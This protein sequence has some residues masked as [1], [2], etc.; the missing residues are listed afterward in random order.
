MGGVAD[1]LVAAK[2]G[3]ATRFSSLTLSSDGGV[4]EP[5]RST[6][7]SF[8]R[9]GRPIPALNKP[10][11]IYARLFGI[12]TG[13]DAK[14]AKLRLKNS[15]NMLDRVLA[16]SK[17]VKGRL[18]THDQRK[19]DEYLESVRTIEQRVERAQAWLDVPKPKVDPN[20]LKESKEPK[21]EEA[22]EPEEAPEEASEDEGQEGGQPGGVPGGV[23]GGKVGGKG[24]FLVKRFGPGM[25]KPKQIGG[26]RMSASKQAV[27]AKIRGL[28]IVE[29]V[30]TA[31]A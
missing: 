24:K 2:H 12:E 6:T 14:A 3:D 20:T 9:E 5:S 4:G 21:K 22:E 15:A 18:G 1:Q 11:Q 28:M 16:H 10:A 13:A 31:K 29:C 27:E 26:P 30:I 19:F 17:S 25:T 7:L 23:A 8:S